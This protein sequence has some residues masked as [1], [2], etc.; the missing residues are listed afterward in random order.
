MSEE[1]RLI[2]MMDVEHLILRIHQVKHKI[3]EINQ[4]I[5]VSRNPLEIR[6]LQRELQRFNL[7]LSMLR[8]RR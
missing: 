2:F 5:R 8:N 7:R 3:N 4:K 6:S 1:I